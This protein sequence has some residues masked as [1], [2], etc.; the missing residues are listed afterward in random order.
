V[1]REPLARRGSEH[2]RRAAGRHRLQLL[3][4]VHPPAGEPAAGHPRSVA[5]GFDRRLARLCGYGIYSGLIGHIDKHDPVEL[6]GDAPPA[7]MVWDVV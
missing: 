4:R 1:A 5:R 6:L 7:G 3:R 2:D